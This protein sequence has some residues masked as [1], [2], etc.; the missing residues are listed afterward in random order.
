[1]NGT[2]KQHLEELFKESGTPF[3]GSYSLEEVGFSWGSGDV[4]SIRNK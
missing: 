1:M 2:Y 4:R 3:L